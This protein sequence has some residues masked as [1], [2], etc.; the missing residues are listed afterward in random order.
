MSGI[1]NNI[2]A[3]A[4]AITVAIPVISFG[5]TEPEVTPR[6]IFA[7]FDAAVKKISRFF[8]ALSR[9]EK[10]A[11]KTEQAKPETTE[12]KI[13]ESA[14]EKRL[15][16]DPE[17]GRVFQKLNPEDKL[18]AQNVRTIEDRPVSPLEQLPSNRFPI[19]EAPA[20]GVVLP[21]CLS[22]GTVCAANGKTYVNACLPEQAKVAI[23]H[24]GPCGAR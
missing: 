13:P 21:N 24:A 9:S 16:N 7:F 1:K 20:S 17:Y 12:K 11:P 4:L 5:A 10:V 18:R 15:K 2:I 22:S 6:S 8:S 3:V 19:F 23:A 14:L